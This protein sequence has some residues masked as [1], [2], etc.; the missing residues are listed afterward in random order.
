MR[1]KLLK[2]LEKELVS[3]KTTKKFDK[4]DVLESEEEEEEVDEGLEEAKL[5]GDVVF[6][7]FMEK[8]TKKVKKKLTKEEREAKEAKQREKELEWKR[9]LKEMK[10]RAQK[11]HQISKRKD[12]IESQMT[13]DKISPQKTLK[14]KEEHNTVK[15]EPEKKTEK[16]KR[17]IK[18]RFSDNL[19]ERR[20]SDSSMKNVDRK[21]PIDAGRRA[22]SDD[23]KE[24]IVKS[25]DSG[26]KVRITPTPKTVKPAQ[27][28]KFCIVCNKVAMKNSVYC[29]KDCMTSYTKE[30]LRLLVEDKLRR[31]GVKSPEVKSPISK[32]PTKGS[33]LTP[34]PTD[35]GDKN[36]RITVVE[37]STKKIIAGVMAPT[38]A[39]IYQWIEEHP[40]FEVFR[41]T[42]TST[43]SGKEKKDLTEVVRNNVKKSLKETILTRCRDVGMEVDADEVSKTCNSIEEEIVKMFGDTGQKYKTKYRSLI[44]NLKD[45]KN[46]SLFKQVV[47]GELTPTKL[48][49]MTPEQ[50]ASAELAKWREREAKHN[51]ELIK[52]REEEEAYALKHA[53]KKTHKGEVEV[54]QDGKEDMKNLQI[55]IDNEEEHKEQHSEDG[56][57]PLPFE[58]TTEQHSSHLFDLNCKIC[59]GKQQPEGEKQPILPHVST[60]VIQAIP[61]SSMQS[62]TAS[63]E[64]M[65]LRQNSPDV[66]ESMDRSPIHIPLPSK[67]RDE[68]VWTGNVMMPS[69]AKF[70]ANA[71]RISGPCDHLSKL[72]PDTAHIYGRITHEQVWDYLYQ[73]KSTAH[74]TIEVL[75]FEMAAEDEKKDYVA[76]YTYFYTRKRIGVIGN[77]YSGVKDMYIVPIAS[78][79]PIPPELKPFDGPGMPDPR[80]HMLI[81]IIVRTKPIVPNK[82]PKTSHH[83]STEHSHKKKK[84]KHKKEEKKKYE[85]IVFG[86]QRAG[87]AL[88]DTPSES[89][90]SYTPS[91]TPDVIS[92][93]SQ[94]PVSSAGASLA[95]ENFLL[96]EKLAEQKLAE[97][98]K[99][100]MKLKAE[101]RAQINENKALGIEPAPE[102]LLETSTIGSPSSIQP[103]DSQ[104]P[105]SSIPGLNASI[106]SVSSTI[107]AT[108]SNYSATSSAALSSFEMHGSS[109]ISSD[110]GR[111]KHV[112]GYSGPEITTASQYKVETIPLISDTSSVAPVK[113][114]TPVSAGLSSHSDLDVSIPG[115]GDIGMLPTT[116]Q[117]VVTE[118]KKIATEEDEP[119]DPE[120]E[121][122]IAMESDAKVDSKEFTKKDVA[123]GDKAKAGSGDEPYDPEDDFVLDLI[124]DIS[125]PTPLKKIEKPNLPFPLEMTKKPENKMPEL[126]PIK[127]PDKVTD[128]RAAGMVTGNTPVDPRSSVSPMG[129][130][131]WTLTPTGTPN[132]HSPSTRNLTSPTGSGSQLTSPTLQRATDTRPSVHTGFEKPDSIYHQDHSKPDIAAYERP[133]NA[134]Q[135]GTQSVPDYW[136]PNHGQEQSYGAYNQYQTSGGQR[137][138]GTYENAYGDNSY[139][140][141]W[142]SGQRAPDS[143]WQG[144]DYNRQ[145][146]N[147]TWEGG[148]HGF[149]APWRGDYYGNQAY[150]NYENSSYQRTH[151]YSNYDNYNRR[152]NRGRPWDGYG[153]RGYYRNRD[154]GRGRG[155]KWR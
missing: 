123:R 83:E 15:Q 25:E 111:S 10:A 22:S 109:S 87:I 16:V 147:R 136:Q 35:E 51:L 28:P 50:L 26:K 122:D 155:S 142:Q 92:P 44:F 91:Y 29:S 139:N 63:P 151:D 79:D 71:Y 18:V 94:I 73:L 57:I 9:Q 112:S 81:G 60:S 38:K 46:R 100:L 125:V 17:E 102:S 19:P 1:K 154:R 88:E 132:T 21:R 153:G 90:G 101:I 121:L 149:N 146:E 53:L 68:P 58:D 59:T 138:G 34:S 103:V 120:D 80:P 148:D 131:T 11:A 27:P 2:A 127:L 31:L 113:A 48:V 36:E 141:H 33:P 140:Q 67:E 145:G 37:R 150:E 84:H 5:E 12:S 85:D 106:S 42:T 144:Y 128:R 6:D 20:K 4:E 7:E 137:P 133:Q 47:Q 55:H 99:E 69:V 76:L 116:S 97:Q 143:S 39:N 75:R 114:A 110:Q 23:H 56:T 65:D 130:G 72:V 96:E 115:L 62:P 52:M 41:P 3:D 93:P 118:E 135:D 78:H 45:S 98:K 64:E 66:I 129:H 105:L 40:T 77:C 104:T 32:D 61:E 82:R 108:P 49:H 8:T 89:G 13:F 74:K 119:Y 30:S 107:S 70:A 24:K 117:S 43:T 86:K 124:E 134:A 14:P 152:D 54:E 95:D 126:P